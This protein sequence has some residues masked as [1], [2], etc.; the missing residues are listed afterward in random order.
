[1]AQEQAQGQAAPRETA[2]AAQPARAKPQPVNDPV[3][4][5]WLLEKW[6]AQSAKLK[7]LDV[8]I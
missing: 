7:T 8:H 4:M 3:K 1:M 2:R 5:K 6:A